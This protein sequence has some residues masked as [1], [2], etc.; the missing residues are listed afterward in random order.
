M[1][2]RDHKKVYCMIPFI[3]KPR[4]CKLINKD[5]KQTNGFQGTWQRV[6]EIDYK[7]A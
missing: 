7:G 2:E 3:Q 6:K 4:K 5:R 1:S